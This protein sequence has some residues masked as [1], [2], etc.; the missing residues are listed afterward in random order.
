MNLSIL[1]TSSNTNS[2]FE[3]KNAAL[4]H[5]NYKLLKELD[6]VSFITPE[7]FEGFS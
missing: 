7:F 2:Y 3:F 4:E 1:N 6:L 5:S